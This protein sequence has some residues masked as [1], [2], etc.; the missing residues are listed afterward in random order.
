MFEFM[1]NLCTDLMV[2][3]D[4]TAGGLPGYL[5]HPI[6]QPIITNASQ[7]VGKTENL[8]PSNL[9]ARIIRCI[10]KQ[11]TMHLSLQNDKSYTV[12]KAP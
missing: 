5:R 6:V 8:K 7:G 9:L 3:Q 11:N 4:P 10:L 1:I 2:L 12:I